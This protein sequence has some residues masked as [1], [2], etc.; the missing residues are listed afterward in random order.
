MANL[1]ESGDDGYAGMSGMTTYNRVE[2]EFFLRQMPSPDEQMV[3][4]TIQGVIDEFIYQTDELSLQSILKENEQVSVTENVYL[5]DTSSVANQSVT[6]F[7]TDSSGNP[8]NRMVIQAGVGSYSDTMAATLSSSVHD[9]IIAIAVDDIKPFMIKGLDTDHT[10]ELVNDK[11][12]NDGYIKHL[13]P[14]K[15]PLIASIESPTILTDAGGPKRVLVFYD[16][17]DLTGEVIAGNTL[18]PSQVNAH[19]RPYHVE[20]ENKGYLVVKRQSLH[21]QRSMRYHLEH[22]EPYRIF[23]SNRIHQHQQTIQMFR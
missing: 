4:Q 10:A 6:S 5:G 14:S 17:I 23:Y 19:Q 21:H 3:R 18:T 15:Q 2:G 8:F 9:E 13:S 16:A 22:I 7:S 11:P 12:T 1:E 20:G